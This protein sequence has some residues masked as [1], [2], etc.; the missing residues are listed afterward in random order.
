MPSWAEARLPAAGRLIAAALLPVML[1]V[2]ALAQGPG[3]VDAERAKRWDEVATRA[4]MLVNNPDTPTEA[5]ETLR[6]ELVTQRSE[7]LAAE[8][9]RQP[10]VDELDKRLHVSPLMGMDRTYAFRASEPGARLA[11]QI[12][13]RPR[14][15]EGRS[16]DATLALRRRELSR[17]LLTRLLARYPALSLQVVAKIYAQS[18]RLKLKGA[19]YFPHPE[20]SKPKGFVSP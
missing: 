1:A 16:F 8:Q 12:E 13:S 5:L 19:R 11:V 6:L 15:R 7:A 9:E 10:P 3:E 14:E 2:A 4:E 17:P 18:L 20:G